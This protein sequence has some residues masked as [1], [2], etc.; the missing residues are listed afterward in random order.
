M[1]LIGIPRGCLTI[2]ALVAVGVSVALTTPVQALEAT[3]SVGEVIFGDE[4]ALQA[5][6]VG[7]IGDLF[8]TPPSGEP[9][10]APTAVPE[11]TAPDEETVTE[12]TAVVR[13]LIACSNSGE[14]L[15]ALTIF[16]DA[17]LRRVVDSSGE[18]DRETAIELINTLATPVAIEAEHLVVL[19]GIRNIVQLA[20]GTVAV[21]LETDGGQPD[22]PGTD[23][24][25]F[26]FKKN[27]DRW[28]IVDAVNDIDEIEARATA[29]SGS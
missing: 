20:D 3:P 4:C 14:V 22:P 23:V 2:A 7:S 21:V 9:Y 28:L 16:D 17:Y 18:L 27:G 25:L 19:I 8:A 24:D 29:V 5:R 1:A 15:R 13:Q 12:V 11:G 6:P 26:I 10:V